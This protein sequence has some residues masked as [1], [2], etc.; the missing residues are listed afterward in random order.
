[1]VSQAVNTNNSISREEY[2]RVLAE[3]QATKKQIAAA[4]KISFKVAED[5]G[6]VSVY[7]LGRFPVSLYKSQWL[8]F[9]AAIG[10]EKTTLH[11]FFDANPDLPNSK[12][13]SAAWKA[14]AAERK[15][16]AAATSAIR[17]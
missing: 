8:R 6:C 15:A 11:A 14:R 10:A 4:V 13:E 3:L 12:E 16:T 1:M 17:K 9:L 5:T 2:E 7:G